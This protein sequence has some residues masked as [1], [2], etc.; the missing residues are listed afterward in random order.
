[1]H[2]GNAAA[3]RRVGSARIGTLSTLSSNST[4]QCRK[5]ESRKGRARSL[6]KQQRV[7]VMAGFTDREMEIQELAAGVKGMS[8]FGA[9]RTYTDGRSRSVQGLLTLNRG[10]R[11]DCAAM[12]RRPHVQ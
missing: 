2:S 11:E 1:M 7:A 5:G 10:K 3:R 12:H 6:W 9:F 4:G 8:A